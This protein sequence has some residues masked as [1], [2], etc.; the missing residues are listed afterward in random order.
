VG[1][2]LG[3]IPHPTPSSNPISSRYVSLVFSHQRRGLFH[4]VFFF[5]R[6]SLY[7][8]LVST[9][10][11]TCRTHVIF[12]DFIISKFAEEYKITKL[13][14]HMILQASGT[15]FLLNPNTLLSSLLWNSLSVL[16]FYY[17]TVCCLSNGTVRISD[18]I[19]FNSRKWT[20]KDAEGSDCGLIW[21]TT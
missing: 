11:T 16:I 8:F 6:Q 5:F 19:G 1:P 14:N 12:L 4:L 3:R 15:S 2:I 13:L 7:A 18:Y 17:G 9:M 21:G 20:A 10:H